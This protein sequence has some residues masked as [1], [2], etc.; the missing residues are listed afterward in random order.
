ME[1][2]NDNYE[3]LMENVVLKAN[4]DLKVYDT[5]FFFDQAMKCVKP[6]VPG[7]EKRK[8]GLRL[9]EEISQRI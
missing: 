8:Q 5:C 9:Y 3:F 7:T 1:F 2:I 6:K 4:F